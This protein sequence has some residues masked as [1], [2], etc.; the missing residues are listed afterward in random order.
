MWR[1]GWML[2]EVGEVGENPYCST[3]ADKEPRLRQDALG[4]GPE[5]AAGTRA[6]RALAGPPTVPRGQRRAA[7][8]WGVD[9]SW[10]HHVHFDGSCQGRRHG[11]L[12]SLSVGVVLPSRGQSR[13]LLGSSRS[14]WPSSPS[15]SKNTM[16]K[17]SP[18]CER[19]SSAHCRARVGARARRSFAPVQVRHDCDHRTSA[20]PANIESTNYL[21]NTSQMTTLHHR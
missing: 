2:G 9:G 15:I 1:V 13:R 6:P 21:L 5:G 7:S 18:G 17:V 12:C 10:S 14:W 3:T 4:R 11:S 16:V 20:D 8:P 19:I